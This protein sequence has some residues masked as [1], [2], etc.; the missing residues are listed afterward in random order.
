MTKWVSFG[1]LAVTA[2]SA[3][4]QTPQDPIVKGFMSR[5]NVPGLA[6]VILQDGNVVAHGEYGVEDVAKKTPVTS[7]SVFPIASLSKPFVALGILYLA[8]HGKLDLT[9]SLGQYVKG[10][11]PDWQTIPLI[12]LLD[13]TSGIP[14][15][16]N[17][18]KWNVRDPA[19][20][21]SDV[22]IEKLITLPL[23]FASGQKYE[24]S[25]GNYALLAKVIEKVSGKPYGEFLTE[26]VFKPLHMDQAKALTMDDLQKSVTG[27][28]TTNGAP[29]AIPW[30]PDWCFGNGALGMSSLDLAKLD[31]GLYTDKVVGSSTLKFITTPQPLNDGT[32]PAY[33]MGWMIG[34]S[35]GTP[36]ISHDGIVS[37]WRSFFGRFTK[38]NLT[39]IVLVNNSTPNLT[40]VANDLAATVVSDLSL[41][42]IED[43][44]TDL[45]RGDRQFIE[46]LKAGT[47]D[48]T[49]L[50]DFMRNDFEKKDHWK[51]IRDALQG[52]GEI[53]A[54]VPA[55]RVQK[56]ANEVDTRYRLEQ[57][58]NV[59]S[60][61]IQRDRKGICIGFFFN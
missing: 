44:F 54:F 22:L 48:P 35:R 40:T 53:T 56:S 38:F 29:E 39:V 31:E 26:K 16:Y 46:A 6:Y 60:I 55:S 49:W 5:H 2:S 15:H 24:Y 3:Q 4:S 1:L 61:T 47:M 41:A 10:L 14:D 25:N 42:P 45:T 21:S 18:G 57:G 43:T 59:S 9:D 27:Y 19:P 7:K 23:H 12:R 50:S 28:R 36:F 51:G 37:G 32:K 30:N 34:V 8:E 20:I 11:P 17:A 52:S 13:H 33:A 58:E